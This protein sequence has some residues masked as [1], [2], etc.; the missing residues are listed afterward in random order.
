MAATDRCTGCKGHTRSYPEHGS[1]AF[2]GLARE[3]G[4]RLS[5]QG[6]HRE[7]G[8]ALHGGESGGNRDYLLM[9]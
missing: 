6:K 1:Q 3:F 5:G 7:N 4:G 8:P 9:L 2:Q